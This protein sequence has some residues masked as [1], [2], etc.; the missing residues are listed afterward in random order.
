MVRV[1]VRCRWVKR[2]FYA[3]VQAVRDS[4]GMKNEQAMIRIAVKSSLRLE[5][6]LGTDRDRVPVPPFI[7]D[8]E[9]V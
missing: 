3:D 7:F 8:V 6:H 5:A 9:D 2:A 4:I 1:K